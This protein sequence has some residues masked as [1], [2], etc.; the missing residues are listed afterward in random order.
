MTTMLLI[1]H[2]LTDAVGERLSGLA[3]GIPL[4]PA[5]EQQVAE[6]VN[7]LSGFPLAAVYSSPIERALATAAPVAASH[8]LEVVVRPRLTELDFGAWTGERFDALAGLA[9]W[10]RFNAYRSGTRIPNG[11]SMLEAQARII[12]ELGH[13]AADHPDAAVAIVSHADVIRAA[14]AHLAGISLDLCLRLEISPCSISVVGLSD[15]PP[16]LLA[17]NDIGRLPR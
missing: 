5:G 12:A 3:A 6:L 14:L 1:R 2:G 4:N 8:G 15:D 13:I 9:A 11:E 17:I 7:R 10:R 16:R